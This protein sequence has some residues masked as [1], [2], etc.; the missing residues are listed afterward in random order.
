MGISGSKKVKTTTNETA[1]TTTN[2]TQS[3]APNPVYAPAINAAAGTLAPA[4]QAANA[5]NQQLLGQ[6]GNVN[7]FYADTLS[8]KYLEGNPY[9]QGM[10][11]SSNRD[12]S[13]IVQSQFEGAGRYGSGYFTDALARALGD[14]E[15]KYR[16]GNYA[17]ERGYQ[18]AAG[19]KILQGTTIS[20]AL[21]QLA[22][23]TYADQ[24]AQLLGRYATQTGTTNQQGTTSGTS[25]SKQSGGLL[26]MLLNAGAQAA[27]AYAASDRRLKRE[28]EKIGELDDGLAVYVWRYLW[29]KLAIGVMADEV[30]EK[31][32]WALGPTF[33]GFAT[34]N[35]GA[36]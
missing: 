18:D 12:V 1:N 23:S 8:G 20:A 13:G 14:N 26:E 5:N 11:D 4:Y 6:V 10:I 34:V 15:L 7:Q 28:V 17:T 31:R 30:A 22:S 3:L 25:T 21:P 27:G 35:Y 19:G 36:L 2:S 16:Y 24:V 9:L 32:P 29:G 33:H